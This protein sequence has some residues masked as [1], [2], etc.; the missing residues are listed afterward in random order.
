MQTTSADLIL[1]GQAT[2]YPDRLQ[3]EYAVENKSHGDS[4]LLEAL[5]QR[6]PQTQK[7]SV[8]PSA[9]F[10]FW[11]GDRTA[12][13]LRGI[14]PLP[15][16][17]N[18]AVRVIPFAVKLAPGEKRRDSLSLPLTLTEDSPYYGPPAHQKVEA[19]A[20]ETLRLALDFLPSTTDGFHAEEISYAP[21]YFRVWS[22]ST[23]SQTIRLTLDL[24]VK[25]VTLLRRTD[26]FSR[27]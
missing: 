11:G 5:Q 2:V 12:I 15:A 20:I 18:V 17:R 16:D 3:I 9:A 25:G 13:I 24:N 27:P 14:P 21:G 26:N 7:P 22:K 6:D 19:V 8:N 10:V 23:I 1:S 4:Y